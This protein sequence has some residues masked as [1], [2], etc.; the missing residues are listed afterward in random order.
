MSRITDEEMD[1]IDKLYYTP[2][3]RAEK[4]NAVLQDS[5]A[6]LTFID[7]T[8]F[9]VQWLAMLATSTLAEDPNFVSIARLANIWLHSRHYN[10]PKAIYG[11]PDREKEKTASPSE[12]ELI[13][14]DE[15]DIK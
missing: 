12:F 1:E 5:K 2:L 10:N 15:R 4:V 14:D 7:N 13:G 6:E 3:E 11:E 9:A 8:C